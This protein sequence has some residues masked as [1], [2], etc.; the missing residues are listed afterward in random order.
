MLEQARQNLFFEGF[1]EAAVAKKAGDADQQ[2]VEE[3]FGLGRL[4]LHDLH[5]VGQIIDFVQSHAAKDAA[6]ERASLVEREVHTG[7]AAQKTQERLDLLAVFLEGV[8]SGGQLRGRFAVRRNIRVFGEA[9]QFAG[10]RLGRED[11]INDACADSAAGHAEMFRG[12]FVLREGEAA[13]AFDFLKA[14]RAIGAGAGKDNPNGAI[15]LNYRQAAEEHVDRH[16]HALSLAISQAQAGAIE[17]SG[18]IGREHINPARGDFRAAADIDHGYGAFV[19]EQIPEATFVMRVQVRN[20][21]QGHAEVLREIRNE[22][23]HGFKAACRCPDADDGKRQRGR[24]DGHYI[25][26]AR[27]WRFKF[28]YRFTAFSGRAGRRKVFVGRV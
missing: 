10:E 15:L 28:L 21:H 27:D 26:V 19:R 9:R 14:E 3:R 8:F 17:D 4:A 5:V 12:A 23:E 6:V 22:G 7:A 18:G 13:L 11:E 1:V 2:I 16:R 25:Q 24:V 20:N